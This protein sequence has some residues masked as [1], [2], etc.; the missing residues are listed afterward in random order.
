MSKPDPEKADHQ[1]PAF[2]VN[3]IRRE[4][5]I[6]DQT[7]NGFPLAYL[8]NAATTQKP[9]TVLDALTRFYSTSN[10]NINRGVHSLSE[11]ATEEYEAARAKAQSFIG[12]DSADEVVFVR[13]V[14]EAVNLVASAFGKK[15]VREGDEILLSEMEHH[16][17]FVP[18]QLL[19]LERGATLRT[20]PI[21]ERGNLMLSDPGRLISDRTRLVSVAH[22][23]N[24]LGTVNPIREIVATAHRGGVPVFVDGA[25]AAPHLRIDVKELDC[26]F[27]AFSGHKLYGPTGIGILYGK[28]AILDEMHPYHGGGGAIGSVSLAGTSFRPAPQKFE[29]GTGNIAGAIGLAAAI[30]YMES[31]GLEPIEDYEQELLEYAIDR[32]AAV[33]GVRIIGDPARRVSIVSFVVEGVHA[34]DVGTILDSVGVAVRSG[35]HCAQPL[36]ERLGLA[37]TVRLSVAFYNLREEIDRLVEGLDRVR[38]IFGATE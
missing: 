1:S 7:I 17:N 15:Y 13:G 38:T 36:H 32:L 23:S 5:P 24:V 29:A 4:F 14:T 22:V 26:D 9:R 31:I 8:D 21:D 6:L 30:D 18:W 19:A 33:P 2:D 16:S 35:H 3:R 12:A 11:R 25:Q 34:H 10:A 27:Y 37:A 28:A 20:I